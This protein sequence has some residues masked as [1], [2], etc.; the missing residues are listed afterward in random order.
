MRQTR[1]HRQRGLATIVAIFSLLV[2]AM[3]CLLLSGL[4]ATGS[5]EARSLLRTKQAF[6]LSDAG[7][8]IS[9]QLLVDNGPTWRPWK[10]GS[11]QCPSNWTGGANDNNT[12]YCAG[13]MTVGNRTGTIKLYICQPDTT[14]G[15]NN[16]PC[17]DAPTTGDVEVLGLGT[18]SGA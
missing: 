4:M 6:F 16:D 5:E 15:D 17:T 18:L 11:Y 2:M 8:L 12:H 9:K 10:D 3:L 14:T 13:T 1:R 7:I